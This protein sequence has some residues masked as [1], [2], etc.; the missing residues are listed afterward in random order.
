[1]HLVGR[2]VDG[3]PPLAGRHADLLVGTGIAAAVVFVNPYGAEPRVFPLALMGRGDV[4]KNVEEWQSRRLPHAQRLR[5]RDLGRHH[6]RRVRPLAARGGASCSSASSFLLLGWWAVRNIAIAV[7]VTIPIVGRCFRPATP[8]RPKRGTPRRR[9]GC[10]VLVALVAVLL[11]G[12]AAAAPDFDLKDRYPVA[13]LQALDSE[14]RLGG[15]LLTTDAW[16]G[17]TIYRYWPEQTVFFDDR[18]DMYPEDMV[19]AYDKV[20]NLEQGWDQVFDQY[21]IEPSCGPRTARSSR[22]CGSC[23]AGPRPVAT[24]SPSPSSV[25]VDPR[26]PARPHLFRA[27]L[28][29]RP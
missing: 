25:A 24:R 8:G 28:C 15:R 4:L 17:Y 1:M 27:A 2:W 5:V 26:P 16:A 6:A 19:E 20:L 9:P 12:R 13:A 10:V 22:R 14:H 18:Y 11:V 29:P 7:A 21:R 3:A 23:R